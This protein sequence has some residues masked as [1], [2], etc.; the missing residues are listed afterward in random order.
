[1]SPKWK[2]KYEPL[3]HQ[4]SLEENILSHLECL[5]PPHISERFCQPQPSSLKE[6]RGEKTQFS[7]V[8]HIFWFLKLAS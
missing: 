3:D 7:S 2:M 8:W 1:M 6:A 5:L 4:G